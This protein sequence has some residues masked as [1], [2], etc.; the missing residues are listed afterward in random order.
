MVGY[1]LN[2]PGKDYTTLIERLKSFPNWWHYLDSTWLIKTDMSAV[3]VR[4][5]LWAVMDQTD[6]LLVID[7]TDRPMAWAGLPPRGSEWLRAA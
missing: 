5:L 2:R 3:Q 4:D 6:E 7:V 1:D